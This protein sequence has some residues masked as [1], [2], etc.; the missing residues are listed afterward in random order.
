M[1]D[2]E[3]VEPSPAVEPSEPPPTP[4]TEPR[5][6]IPAITT[7]DA[8]LADLANRLG[9]GTGPVAMDA[10]RA[11][12]Y[13]YGQRIY[14]LQ[15]R[16]DGV[17][18]A[19]VDP[20]GIS[21][22]VTLASA[23]GNEEWVLH[24]ASQDLPCL[25]EVGLY[26]TRVFD[27]ELAARLL[28]RTRVGLGPLVADVL[29]LGLEKG[30]AAA[31]WST[32]PL[33]ESWLRYAALDVEV[34]LELR[35]ALVDE[36]AAAGKTEWARQE[37][38]AIVA[39]PPA[40]PRIDP[41][42]RTSGL[43]RIRQRRALAIVAALWWARDAVARQRD[44]AA[45]RIIPDAAIV[46]AGLAAPTSKAALSALPEFAGRGAQRRIGTWWEA[47]ASAL[48]LPEADL[49]PAALPADG[50]PPPR[51]WPERDPKAAK[52]LAQA[53]SALG[54]LAERLQLP[55]ENLLSP[56]AVRR[57]TWS[58]PEPLSVDAVQERLEQLGAR[59]WQLGLTVGTLTTACIE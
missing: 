15:L 59:Q 54:E 25:A 28:G 37:F 52:R 30:H 8:E 14:L 50:P 5:D 34:L 4:L 36:L 16:R 35:A 32:R 55:L 27:T 1:S 43:H 20:I 6:G 26:P 17:G 19:L 24:A 9:A 29:G 41:W 11:S 47:I 39:A 53:R 13:R 57:V 46:A 33:P 42:R 48:A 3:A 7:T 2:T 22:F 56:D 21:D 12:G 51:T 10:E 18:S 45:G 38:Q 31:D 49:P 44:I 23:I 40:V 58:P